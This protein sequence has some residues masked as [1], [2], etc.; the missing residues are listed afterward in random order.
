MINL[1]Y[2]RLKNFAG[3]DIC[4]GKDEL[5]IDRYNSPNNI[6]IIAGQNGSYKSSLL[7]ELTPFSLEHTISRTTKRVEKDKIAEKELHFV[8]E[9]GIRYKCKIYYDKNKTSA[10]ITRDDMRNNSEEIELN[11][12]GN[13]SSY[14]EILERELGITKNYQQ[15]GFLTPDLV[16]FISMK[17]ADRSRYLSNF[18]PDVSIYLKS[19]DI[20]SKKANEKKKEIDNLNKELGKLSSI[21]Y[22]NHINQLK[23]N[24][25]DLNKS[26]DKIKEDTTK[27]KMFLDNFEKYQEAIIQ[28]EKIKQIFLKYTNEAEKLKNKIYLLKES[29]DYYNNNGGDKKLKEDLLKYEK[30]LSTAKEKEYSLSKNI[31]KLI[32]SIKEKEMVLEE[33]KNSLEIQSLSDILAYIDKYTLEY[34]NLNIELKKL[35]ENNSIMIQLFDN[36]NLNEIYDFNRI[37]ELILEISSRFEKIDNENIFNL[38]YFNT[39]LIEIEK[40]YNSYN[41]E[42]ENNEKEIKELTEKIS[43]LKSNEEMRRL[44]ELRENCIQKCKIIQELEKYINI[45]NERDL[46]I[47]NKSLL[48]DKININK[49]RLE[50]CELNISIIQKNINNIQNINNIIMENSNNIATFSDKIK[51][52]FKLQEIESIVKELK[53]I[54]INFDSFKEYIHLKE[55]LKTLSNSIN[56]LKI[57]RNISISKN[58]IEKEVKELDD[59]KKELEILRTETIISLESEINNLKEISK[60]REII[61]SDINNYNLL[62]DELLDVK[63]K[64]ITIANIEYYNSHLKDIMMKLN[65]DKTFKEKEL[66][67]LEKER[68]LLKSEYLN[69]QQLEKLRNQYLEI[70]NK[71]EILKN[72]WSVR[73]GYPSILLES[74]LLELKN[75]V[76]KNLNEIWD[77]SLSIEEFILTQSEFSIVMNREGTLISDASQLSQGERAIMTLA[78]SFSIIEMNLKEKIY[79]VIR[80][81]EL[82]ATLDEIRSRRFLEMIRERIDRMNVNSCFIISHRS[83]FETVPADLILLKGARVSNT[84]NK[85]IIYKI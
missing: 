59:S 14:E 47:K 68:E 29:M 58:D 44:Y 55:K 20:V 33:S 78:I 75:D 51:E 66:S 60:N 3:L 43:L 40:L 45:D 18:L 53:I 15:I 38:N 9:T 52:I 42:I 63:S 34:N 8:L 64:L 73:D 85:N 32:L 31:D 36:M 37:L 65:I 24:I 19:Y 25:D 76:N 1:V 28:K 4:I 84:H 71:Y 23:I 80:L 67:N 72:I 5:E 74:F 82:D 11:P 48:E 49:K 22:E 54:K 13:I 21:N 57:Q 79:D 6:I 70:K 39:K 26:L 50:Q 30:Q 35:E 12:N 17:A 7:M 41:L 27:C 62:R 83:E 56:E 16:N 2:I 10:Y 77:N 81:D 69:K 61:Q 46:M